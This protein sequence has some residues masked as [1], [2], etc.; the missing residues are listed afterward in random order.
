MN[1]GELPQHP[2]FKRLIDGLQKDLDASTL[3]VLGATHRKPLDEVRYLS[4]YRKHC[5]DLIDTLR[6]A[7]RKAR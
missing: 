5:E 2:D 6:E 3:R 4:G 1:L 7:K